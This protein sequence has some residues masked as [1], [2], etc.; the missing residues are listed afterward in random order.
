MPFV[1]V[2]TDLADYPPH[3]W[4]EP[5]PQYFICGTAEA[6]QQVIS[7]GHAADRVFLT[8]GMILH[9][10]FY[11]PPNSEPA[12]A[13]LRM[14]LSSDRPTGLVLFGAEGSR[15]IEN[16]ATRLVR[17]DIDLQLI[18]V[19]GRNTGLADRLRRTSW[20]KPVYIEGFSRDV[21]SIMDLSDFMIGKPGPGS[22]SEAMARGLPVIVDSN[23]WTLPQ[24]RFNV[25]W[26]RTKEVGLVVSDF[27]DIVEAVRTLRD[28]ERLPRYRANVAALH[29][30]A[31]FEMPAILDTILARRRPAQ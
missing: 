2:L 3:F 21:A 12:K 7:Q 25:E 28:P 5:E 30:R 23:A 11:V 24:E 9:P 19:C 16:I 29:N 27:D 1:T 20:Q 22:I 26:L 13:R 14:G 4:V 17:S 8:S 10:K 15:E 31:V 18:L 6:V